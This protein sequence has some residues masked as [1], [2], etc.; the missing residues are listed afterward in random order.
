MDM[1]G[2]YGHGEQ[3]LR[4]LSVMDMGSSYGAFQQLWTVQTVMD[5]VSSY[6][7][8]NGSW[9]NFPQSSIFALTIPSKEDARHENF[10]AQAKV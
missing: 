5:V 6:D 4:W 9:C 7:R 10:R 3:L 2:S 1:V 8:R